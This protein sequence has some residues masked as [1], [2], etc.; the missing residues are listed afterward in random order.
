VE[1]YDLALHPGFTLV[2]Q[3]RES[4][5]RA[6]AQRSALGLD[7]AI[8]RVFLAQ[9]G[10]E[11]RHDAGAE[12]ELAMAPQ[13]LAPGMV[14]SRDLRS[15][16]NVLLLKAGTE[17]TQALIE[18]ILGHDVAENAIATAYV[19]VG[20]VPGGPPEPEAPPE[21]PDLGLFPRD[22]WSA[23]EGG[24]PVVL[25]LHSTL[26]TLLALRRD[27]EPLG[28]CV[29]GGA[30]AARADEP[31]GPPAAVLVDLAAGAPQAAESIRE[32]A[33]RPDP[34]HCLAIGLHPS[35]DDVAALAGA[36]NL[37]RVLAYPRDR[38]A[39]A[40]AVREVLDRPHRA[41]AA[42]GPPAP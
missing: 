5:R 36:R 41:G 23:G 1:T 42:G 30:E 33:R 15:I 39:L 29:R 6:V 26:S 22:V 21:T 20:S 37:V 17:L 4:A 24:R 32:L 2:E 27:L 8:V 34:L 7:P 28:L 9:L 16:G 14:L 13:T 18:R 11:D 40:D 3:N 12:R 19:E 10:R 31:D 35:A 25:V 38:D